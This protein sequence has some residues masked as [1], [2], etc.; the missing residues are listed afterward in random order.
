MNAATA[1]GRVLVDELARAGVSD[2][3]LAPG[4]RSAPLAMAFH[5]DDRVRVHVEIDERSAGFLALGLGKAG[6]GPAA[7][8]TTSGT[9]TANVHPAVVE[10][11]HDRVPLLVLTADRPPPLRHTAA[12]QTIDQTQ[13]YGGSVRW[14]VEV[15]AADP[16]PPTVAYW[17]SL[18]AR[19]VAVARA[20]PPGPVHLNVA[21]PEP[22]VPDPGAGAPAAP[23]G[24][25]NARPWTAAPPPAVAVADETVAA[26]TERVAAAERGL[27]AV[28]TTDADP[29]P[30]IALAEAA[31]WPIVAEPLSGARAGRHAL[32]T[33]HHLLACERFAAGH[34]PD[35]VVRVGR[36]GLSRRLLGFLAADV[37]QVL[38]DRDGAWLDPT[39]SLGEI[40]T[41]EPAALCAAV[42][43]R[44]PP[45]A[46]S[47]WLDDW[48]QAEGR[49]RAA[50]DAHLDAEEA[51][52]EPR[53]ARDLAAA[54]PD[55][56][57]LVAASS[58]PVRDLDQFMAPRRGL[59]VLGNRG[60]SGIDGFVSTALGVALA[61]DG[62]ATALAGDLSV[63]HDQN[64]FLL[65]D[66][67]DLVLVVVNN[68]GG[69]I[70]SFLPQAAHPA[71]F[72][73]LF[74]TPHG[75]DFGRLAAVYGLGHVRVGAA[76]DLAS[77][78]EDARARGGVA[79]VE[80]RTDR[81][82]NVALHRRV[83]EVVRREVG[84]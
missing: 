24:R 82:R 70:F 75:V 73:Q 71:S 2:A 47:S 68:D 56:A 27:L 23:G 64:G 74:G 38:V 77:A 63:L 7:V 51:P 45:P 57:V 41:A 50:L 66:R 20:R 55:G 65:A 30:L 8:L 14:F 53:T 72:E 42:A 21:L 13:L 78:V 79:L 46:S 1:L 59:R 62:P 3:V 4:S 28:G 84:G 69:G 54:L 43:A 80:V 36:I 67:P 16:D 48:L 32:S 58:M 5:D 12:N 52:S 35:L 49:A 39:R 37:A 19:A 60:A 25:P 15:G 17:R 81:T 26:L 31:G 83:D 76:G 11:D 29:E 34:R 61:A 33:A 40:V 22:L 6:G 9:A 18:A 44:L 10:A